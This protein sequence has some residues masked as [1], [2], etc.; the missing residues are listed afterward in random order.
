MAKQAKVLTDAELKRVYA[1]CD[2]SRHAARN[3]LDFAAE[4]WGWNASM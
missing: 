4:L 2:S 1:I 3:R